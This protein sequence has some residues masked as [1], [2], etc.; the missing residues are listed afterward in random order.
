MN[1]GLELSPEEI[2]V[3]LIEALAF[4]HTSKVTLVIMVCQ[5]VENPGNRVAHYT[6]L[7]TSSKVLNDIVY[8]PLFNT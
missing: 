8:L 1:K 4:N 3:N 2:T 5:F 7:H 6:L